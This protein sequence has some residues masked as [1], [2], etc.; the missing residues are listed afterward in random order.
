MAFQ[1]DG[2]MASV[3]LFFVAVALLIWRDRKKIEFHWIVVMRRTRRFRNLIDRVAQ[4]G[5]RFWRNFANIGV[6]AALVAAALGIFVLLL[7]ARDIFSGVI[8]KP[9]LQF[10]LPTVASTGASGPGFVLIPFWIWIAVIAAILVPH[11]FMHGV[12]ARA[13]KIS[14]KSVG[15][16]LFLIFPGAFVEPD[17]GQLKRAKLSTRL[18]IFA[19]GSWMNF[20]TALLAFLF[21]SSVVW[22][23]SV[24]PSVTFNITAV[25]ES[26]PAAAAGLAPGVLVSK[27]NGGPIAASYNEYFSGAS[28]IR[29]EIG[30][31]KIGDSVSF[32]DSAGKEYEMEAAAHPT[33]GRPYLGFMGNFD[34]PV[35]PSVAAFLLPFLTLLWILSLA[36]GV[37]NILPLYP[38]DGGLF[39]EALAKR[40]WPARSKQITRG[41]TV[42]V[43]LLLIY[44]FVGPVL[45]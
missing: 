31:L 25:N 12:V 22:P 41:V 16:L 43:L 14:L 36:V 19:A 26:S 8:T 17:E 30:G 27:I 34:N 5:P 35:S 3:I 45:V 42:F 4:A 6:G 44:S 11:E 32:A 40:F 18:R 24:Q 39:F 21:V 10:I 15:L 28:F 13:E 7:T 2:Y 38:L 9:A 1:V 20:V 23:V 37:V 33:T 29:E